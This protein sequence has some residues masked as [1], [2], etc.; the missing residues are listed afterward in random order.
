[1]KLN[2]LY[3][4]ILLL[5]IN[6][7]YINNT[8]TLD[9]SFS[10]PNSNNNTLI[11]NNKIENN[12]INESFSK[13]LSYYFSIS[14][15]VKLCIGDPLQCFLIQI[16]FSSYETILNL[17]SFN[18]QYMDSSSFRAL[19]T[20]NTTF[21]G[22]DTIKLGNEK[23]NLIDNYNFILT[24]ESYINIISEIGLGKIMQYH[25]EFPAEYDF[26]LIK[27]L[28]NKKMIES[29]EITIKYS[30]DFSGELILGTNYTGMNIDESQYLELPNT[31]NSLNGYLQ[32]IY[33]EDAT[34]ST[35]KKQQKD[36]LAQEKRKRI[37]LDFNSTFIKM[38]EEIF[39][40]IKLISF[41][42][43]INAEIC[44]VKKNEKLEIEYLICKDDILNS[45]LD[46]LFIIFNWKKNI[47]VSLNDLFLPYNSENEKK[48]N[49]FGIISSKDNNTIY[50]GTVLLKKYMICLNREKNLIR[51]YLKNIQLDAANTDIFGIV[52][53]I[54]LTI[55]ICMLMIYM[56]STICGK[57]KY[58]PTYSPHVQKFLSK[59][60][61]DSS[62]KSNDT[63]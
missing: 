36:L 35:T 59:K 2:F 37:K 50:I 16:S 52:G 54:T 51:L 27:Q 14:P 44:E 48:N 30:D 46:R 3:F 17:N 34:I 61:L 57:D 11:T 12:P 43:Y 42:S 47:S 19:T 24:N 13:N 10:L 22:S 23:K 39:N 40:Q 53:I 33:I 28:N 6:I 56:V 5:I 8:F 26:S 7:N 25:Y 63:F 45:N 29:S 18:F 32:S 41:I 15:M 60:T 21:L 55:I 31:E 1:M 58:E 49:I 20:I 4:F 9:F 62:F 38:P